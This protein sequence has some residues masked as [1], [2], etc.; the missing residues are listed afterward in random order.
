MGLLQ[1]LRGGERLEGASAA[2]LRQGL[3]QGAE[4]TVVAECVPSATRAHMLRGAANREWVR[5]AAA[6]WLAERAAGGVP[7]QLVLAGVGLSRQG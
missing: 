3:K 2:S 4:Q 6:P 5:S 1:L 7:Q